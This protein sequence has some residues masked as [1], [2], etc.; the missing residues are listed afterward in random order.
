MIYVGSFSKTLLPTLRIGFIVAP[1]SVRNAMLGAK[2][3]MDW[4]S[5]LPMQAALA[6]FIEEGGFARHLRKMRGVY[7]KR[8]DLIENTLRRDFAGI[9]QVLPSSAG[10]HVG[11]LARSPDAQDLRDVLARAAVLGL[12]VQSMASFTTDVPVRPGFML[13]FGCIATGRIEEGLRRLRQA[14][15]AA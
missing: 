8:H 2:F 4:H 1:P 15:D 10:L 7:E 12:S 13:G 14:F 3:V 6:G 11:V 9:L 5:S